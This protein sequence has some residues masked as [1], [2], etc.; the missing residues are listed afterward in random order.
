MLRARRG[1]YHPL[2]NLPLRVIPYLL[3]LGVWDHPLA[4]NINLA[5][6]MLGHLFSSVGFNINA[7]VQIS[8]TP[9]WDL[10]PLFLPYVCDCRVY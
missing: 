7:G 2:E 4:M 3:V 9:S 5:I 6:L 10:R 1:Y 8:L